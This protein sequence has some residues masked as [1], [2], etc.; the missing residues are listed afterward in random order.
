MPADKRRRLALLAAF[1]L[2]AMGPMAAH[3]AGNPDLPTGPGSA[4]VLP[5]SG[6]ATAPPAGLDWSGLWQRSEGITHPDSHKI[7]PFMTPAARAIWQPKIDAHDFR[8]PWS[9]C[10]PAGIPAILTDIAR[11][12]EWLFTPGR[13]TQIWSDGE[14]RR[15]YTDGRPHPPADE[16]LPSYLGDA[17][18][19][20]EG[21]TLVIDTVALN[22]ENN[23][24]MGVPA[25]GDMHVV[26]HIHL[27][28]KDELRDDIEV[29]GPALL[30]RPYWVTQTYKRFPKA[31]VV[32]AMCVASKNRNTGTSVDLTPPK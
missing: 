22:P 2:P 14:L 28:G 18:G 15:I 3:A 11:P 4:L 20:W 25:E 19:H 21:R 7:L 16:A 32:E 26:E 1:L 31:R 29:T 6:K 10:D 17:I 8:V 13:V 12:T 30:A 5:P 23:I 9:F 27:T 24:V